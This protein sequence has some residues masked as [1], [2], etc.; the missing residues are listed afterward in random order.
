MKSS[1][2]TSMTMT[3]MMTKGG[4]QWIALPVPI[5]RTS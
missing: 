1:S 3:M 4:L 2:M 5:I